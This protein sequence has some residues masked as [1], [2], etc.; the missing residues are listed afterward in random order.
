MSHNTYIYAPTGELLALPFLGAFA[1]YVVRS[2]AIETDREAAHKTGTVFGIVVAV[3]FWWGLF[4]VLT[5][6]FWRVAIQG[7]FILMLLL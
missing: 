7:Y 6:N 2:P 5:P 4:W 1:S 3:V